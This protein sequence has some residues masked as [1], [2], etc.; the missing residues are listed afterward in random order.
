MAC[1]RCEYAFAHELAVG[2]FAVSEES[3]TLV[4]KRVAEAETRLV[5]LMW[6]SKHAWIL[7]FITAGAIALPIIVGRR[8]YT[9]V[10]E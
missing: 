9:V 7:F 5:Q 2:G 8:L 3:N 6:L 1:S 4:A 10:V